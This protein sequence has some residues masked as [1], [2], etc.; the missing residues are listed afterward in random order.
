MFGGYTCFQ[1]DSKLLFVGETYQM[2]CKVCFYA[3][4]NFLVFNDDATL[5]K[6][7]LGAREIV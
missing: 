6:K 1:N 7:V 5:I 4:E 3:M 2:S